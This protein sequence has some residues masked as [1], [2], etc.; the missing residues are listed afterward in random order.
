MTTSVTGPAAYSAPGS[1]L[2]ADPGSIGHLGLPDRRLT[3]YIHPMMGSG[4]GRF[5]SYQRIKE[6]ITVTPAEIIYQRRVR[7]LEH[8]ANV[9]NVIEAF[10]AFHISR[11]RY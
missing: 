11:A 2:S 10:R 9:G 1:T 8:A 3:L 4:D 5:G 7:L 6:P